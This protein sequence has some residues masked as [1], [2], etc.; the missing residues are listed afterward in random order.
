VTVKLSDLKRT[1]Q[2]ALLDD[3]GVSAIVGERV[4]GAHRVDPEAPTS[5]Y[6]HVVVSFES[7]SSDYSGAIQARTFQL[8]CMSRESMGQAAQLY[9][10]CYAVLQACTHDLVLTDRTVC[11]LTE[12]TQGVTEGWVEATRAHFARGRWLARAVG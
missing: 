7:G 12:E 11:V 10:A 1:V 6:P 4:F 3:S 5:E 2:H 9:D 8:W